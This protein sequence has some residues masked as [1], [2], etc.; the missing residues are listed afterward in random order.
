MKGQPV[1]GSHGAP[2]KVVL[3]SIQPVVGLGLSQSKHGVAVILQAGSL[4]SR[5]LT[6]IG[7]A[8]ESQLS[9]LISVMKAVTVHVPASGGRELKLSSPF[10]S[11][12]K[13]YGG[14]MPSRVKPPA[15]PPVPP[16]SSLNCIAYPPPVGI[17]SPVKS[18]IPISPEQRSSGP[19]LTGVPATHV[20]IGGGQEGSLISRKLTII[21][22]VVGPQGFPSASR[23]IPVT[24]HVPDKF[25]RLLPG[26]IPLIRSLNTQGRGTSVIVK[27]PAK[28]PVPPI[29]S[30][31]PT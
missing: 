28:P 20:V 14:I 21:G 27:P 1:P 23:T 25:G 11:S 8:V 5:K 30:L 19:G 22:S 31:K 7:T 17:V 10:R 15:R 9:P 4:A 18:K 16:M 24:T 2:P 13:E 6:V 26:K 3:K 29:A 12:S